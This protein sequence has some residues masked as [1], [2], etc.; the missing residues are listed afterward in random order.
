MDITATDFKVHFTRDFPYLPIWDA[1]K[2]YFKGDIVYL[3]P[4]FYESLKDSNR[5]AVSMTTDWKV[6]KDSTDGYIQDT[7]IS[8]AIDEARLSFNEELFSGCEHEAKMA[9]LYLTAYYMVVDIKNSSAGLASGYAGF[10]ASKSVGNVSESYGIPSWVQND[11]ML[12]LYLDNG[13]GKKYLTFLLPR[14]S[15]FIYL[16]KGGITED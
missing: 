12:S 16:A 1:K 7:D 2:T 14:V 15:G 6:I 3:Y 13:Y 10:T 8:K 4:N 11:P 5:S 9:M